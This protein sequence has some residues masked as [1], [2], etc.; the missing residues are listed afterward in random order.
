MV[1]SN[2]QRLRNG[3]MRSTYMFDEQLTAKGQA[4]TGQG[5]HSTNMGIKGELNQLCGSRVDMAKAVATVFGHCEA[6]LHL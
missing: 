3:C 4:E 2:Y 6:A 1:P 5:R